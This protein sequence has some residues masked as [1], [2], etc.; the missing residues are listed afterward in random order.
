MR[1]NF[2]AAFDALMGIEGGYSNNPADPGG[3]TMWGITKRVALAHDYHGDMRLLP[4]EVAMAIARSEYWDNSKCDDLADRLDFQVFDAAYN[5]GYERANEW[6]T[7]AIS[8]VP[9]PTDTDKIILRFNAIRLIFMTSLST[10]PNFGKG[11]ARRIGGNLL[12]A[13]S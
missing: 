6:Y 4:K 8:G 1:E 12:R 13:G 10:W 9:D 5:S 2:D 3:E 11:W 7:K